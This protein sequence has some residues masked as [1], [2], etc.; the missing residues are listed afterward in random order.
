MTPGSADHAAAGTARP[1]RRWYQRLGS[2]AWV[3]FCFELGAFLL[4]YPWMDEWSRN[5][6]TALAGP[7]RVHWSSPYLRGAVSGLGIVNIY[8]ALVDLY[9][10][11]K[12]CFFD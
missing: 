9:E 11:L 5:S 6:I 2:L 7:L 8:I 10:F 4:V 1:R 3:I 12:E